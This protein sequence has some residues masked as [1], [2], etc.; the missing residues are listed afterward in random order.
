MC[1]LLIKL[2]FVDPYSRNLMEGIRFFDYCLFSVKLLLLI[3][4]ICGTYDWSQ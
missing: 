1:L 4:G 2:W 3:F